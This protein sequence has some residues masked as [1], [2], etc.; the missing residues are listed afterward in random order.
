MIVKS[1]ALKTMLKLI[2]DKSNI[3]YFWEFSDLRNQLADSS[4]FKCL[5]T[6]LY[7]YEECLVA[8]LFIK[9]E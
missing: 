7:N 9:N 4:L 5:W 6:G 8:R 1:D 2:V 3:K